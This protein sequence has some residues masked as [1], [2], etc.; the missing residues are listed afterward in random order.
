VESVKINLM[1]KAVM[2]ETKENS[3]LGFVGIQW[4][5]SLNAWGKGLEDD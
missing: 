5:L 2:C 1:D 3:F 4:K